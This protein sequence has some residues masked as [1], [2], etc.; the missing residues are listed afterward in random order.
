LWQH[1]P[2]CALALSGQTIDGQI[3][4]KLIRTSVSIKETVVLIV[5]IDVPTRRLSPPV[6]IIP[7]RD[8]KFKT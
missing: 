2:L 8:V 4:T 7:A 3:A 6:K 1:P 5:L